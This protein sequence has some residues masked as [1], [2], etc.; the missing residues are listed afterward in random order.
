[1]YSVTLDGTTDLLLGPGF[2]S[3]YLACDPN[4]GYTFVSFYTDTEGDVAV[5]RLSAEKRTA[6]VNILTVG[7]VRRA[8][9]LDVDLEGNLYIC[10]EGSDN[11]VQMSGDGRHVRELL[12]SSDGINSPV[13]IAVCG[14]KF[15]VT[16]LSEEEPNV[17]HVYQLY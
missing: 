11:V 12:T 5:A 9:G 17:V 8:T 2:Q 3:Y 14:E 6:E 4:N 15:V 16:S 7:V 13:G 10:G 1:M